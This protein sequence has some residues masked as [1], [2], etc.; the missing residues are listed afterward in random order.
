MFWVA[1][2]FHILIRVIGHIALYAQTIPA[3]VVILL[4]VTIINFETALIFDIA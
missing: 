3:D 2:L 1:F 4:L